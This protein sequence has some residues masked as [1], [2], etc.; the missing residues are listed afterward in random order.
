MVY[1]E[2]KG[3]KT[4][5]KTKRKELIEQYKSKKAVGGIYCIKCNVN[6]R[7]W[8][9]TT[10]DMEGQKN[11]YEFFFST[12]SC[13][14]PS[15]LTEWNQYGAK[16]FSFEILEELKQGETQTDKEFAEDMEVLLKIWMEKQQA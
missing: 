8:I 12:N 9:K 7:T 3:S 11:R 4:M 2:R 13:P 6:N 15:M 5:D 1:I 16:T 14:E 10:R